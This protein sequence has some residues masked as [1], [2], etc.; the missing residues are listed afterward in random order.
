MW[1]VRL[2]SRDAQESP[3]TFKRPSYLGSAWEGTRRPGPR[4]LAGWRTLGRDPSAT[5]VPSPLTRLSRGE[6][7]Q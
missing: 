1:S 2:P 7:L 4:D 3:L 5:P 6:A